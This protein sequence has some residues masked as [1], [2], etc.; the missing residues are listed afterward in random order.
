MKKP[1][2]KAF[3]NV[4]SLLKSHCLGEKIY[5][6]PNPGNG[7]DSLIAAGTFTLFD[8]L[9]LDVKIIDDN[10]NPEGKIIIYAGGG[11]FNHIYTDASGFIE[12]V[13]RA[14]KMFILLPHTVTGNEYLLS[15]LGE[16]CHI[17]ARE[18]VTYDYLNGVCKGCNVYL[19]H[20]MAL[21][22]RPEELLRYD[23][24]SIL[25]L[26]IKKITRKYILRNRVDNIPSIMSLIKIALFESLPGR[27][28]GYFFRKDAERNALVPHKGFDLSMI[29][30]LGTSNK[31]VVLLTARRILKYLARF[32][33]VYTD[34][35]HVGIGSLLLNKKVVLF[36]GNY[37]K[38]RSIYEFSLKDRFKI[39][40]KEPV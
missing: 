19:D 12:K 36:P 29:Y 15:S 31:E 7:G 24:E 22:L 18:L 13:H 3:G 33:V 38:I 6:K 10:V 11:N 17:F 20:D 2:Y 1:D 35:L 25:A 37:H 14:A 21:Y 30:E 4:I 39:E 9:G 34:R 32:D 8:D 5:Y 40:L 27:K 16:N 28:A 26:V 23:P